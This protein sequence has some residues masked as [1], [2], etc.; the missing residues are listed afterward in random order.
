MFLSMPVILGSLISLA[1]MSLYIPLIVVRLL[2][3]EKIL[4][5]SLPGYIEYKSKV[6]YRIIPFLW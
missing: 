1:V 3:E 6:R 5:A 2:G 4:E